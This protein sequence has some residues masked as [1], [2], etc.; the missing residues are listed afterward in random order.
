MGILNVTPDS[1]S[2]G[3]DHL[4]PAAAIAAGLQMVEDGA[5]ILDIGGE[6]TSPGSPDLPVDIEVARI[7]PVIT[8]LCQCGVPLS[9]D[10]RNAATMDAALAAGAAIVND[11]SALRHDPASARL[12]AAAGC[13]VILMP[14]AWHTGDD[15][16]LCP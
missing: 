1:F 8:G 13:A 12:V 7:V 3:G 5:G 16:P 14:Y 11:V 10:T 4:V 6:T 9:V 15:E 2:D